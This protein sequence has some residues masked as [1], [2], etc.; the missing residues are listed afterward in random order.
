MMKT[1]L[2]SLK[3]VESLLSMKQVIES[4]TDGY[5]AFDEGKVQ[6][7]DIVSLEMPQHNGET[8]IKSCYNK[9]N[10]TVSVKIASGF[11]DNGKVNGLPSM[12]GAILL[13]TE[14]RERF[15]ALWT[16]V[17][18]QTSG[19][20]RREPCHAGCWQE[21]IQRPSPY[22]AEEVR[23]ECRFTAYAP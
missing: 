2:L 4:V 9:M 13:L 21:K 14:R 23:R 7:P 5:R 6:Q 8:D 20:V 22:S 3:D 10:E 18:S 19:R 12:I 15:C 1:L 11:Y 17:L 16:E